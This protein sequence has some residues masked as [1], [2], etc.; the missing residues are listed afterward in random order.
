VASFYCSYFR[1][2]SSLLSWQAG[3]QA[4]RQAR[5]EGGKKEGRQQLCTS[6]LIIEI[7]T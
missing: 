7:G 2:Q 6:T 4:G 5:R 1:L 3:R